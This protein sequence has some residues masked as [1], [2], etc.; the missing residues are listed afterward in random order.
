MKEIVE[1]TGLSKGAFYHY[2]SSK[3]QLFMEIMDRFFTQTIVYNFERYSDKSLYQ[4][5]Q[6]HLSDLEETLKQWTEEYKLGHL[7]QDMANNYL[8]PLFDAMFMFPDYAKKLNRARQAELKAWTAAVKRARISG[9]IHSS[10]TDEQIARL[11]LFSGNGTGLFAIM[12]GTPAREMISEYRELWE[13][14]YKSLKN[15]Q[16]GIK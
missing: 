9:E 13:A 14:L 2:F 16:I 11:F 6:D 3:E 15:N 4:F 12:I 8:H 7:T 5:C 1:K 10:M